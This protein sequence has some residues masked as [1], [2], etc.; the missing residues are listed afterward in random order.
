MLCSIKMSSSMFGLRVV[1]TWSMGDNFNLPS[2]LRGVSWTPHDSL[3]E[4][5]KIHRQLPP[6]AKQNLQAFP[7]TDCVKNSKNTPQHATFDD[8]EN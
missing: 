5:E 2:L 8:D 3:S 7:N 4:L 1:L 6:M